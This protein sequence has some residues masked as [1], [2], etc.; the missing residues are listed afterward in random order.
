M[1]RHV[2]CDYG[3]Y[4]ISDMKSDLHKIACCISSWREKA[5]Q[6]WHLWLR[7]LSKE[8]HKIT[9]CI[10]S[11]R[12]KVTCVTTNVLEK[13]FESTCCISSWK[14]EAV[15]MWH[16]WLYIKRHTK[17]VHEQKKF[18]LN[19]TIVLPVLYNPIIWNKF[20]KEKQ[21]LS[22]TTWHQ[23]YKMAMC[24]KDRDVILQGIPGSRR[25]IASYDSYHGPLSLVG[26]GVDINSLL[27]AFSALWLQM[28]HLFMKER[29][30]LNATFV[31]I[32]VLEILTWIYMLHLYMKK[33]PF[34]CNIRPTAVIHQQ[35]FF[36]LKDEFYRH[37]V[38]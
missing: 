6:M 27:L 14:K 8:W 31:T 9:C 38:W 2:V 20:I 37:K 28:L 25:T 22:N 7:L 34:K 21:Q 17:S 26:L 1:N 30:N 12:E 11:W 19:V 24:T 5:N 36:K 29:S 33:P 4:Q 10:S 15:Q 18:F 16:L 23:L 32:D 3:C 35:D 13:Y